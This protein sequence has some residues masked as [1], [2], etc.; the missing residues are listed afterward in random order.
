M[1]PFL[2][3][4]GDGDSL[5][6]LARLGPKLA[7]G[8]L[9][10]LRA[11]GFL[12]PIGSR[13]FEE[14]SVPDVIRTLRALWGAGSGGVRTRSTMSP[15][16]MHL[17]WLEI[18]DEPCELVLVMGDAHSLAAA[19]RRRSRALVLVPTDRAMT[20][21]LRAR[22]DSRALVRFV[23]LSE[24]LG[25]HRGRVCRVDLPVP[26]P[27]PL[28]ARA[29]ASA[30]RP[31]AAIFDGEASWEQLVLLKQD[32]RTLLARFERR[33]RRLTA[34]DLGLAGVRSRKACAPFEMLMAFCENDGCLKTRRFGNAG[35]TKATLSRL[36]AGLK[37]AFG[38]D[39]DPFHDFQRGVGWLARFGVS[40][41]EAEIERELSP[42]ARAVLERAGKVR[43]TR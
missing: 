1:R 35:A 28:P 15:A 36:R 42:G 21:E 2:Q 34:Q 5:A 7:P 3:L 18:D 8:E 24:C 20:P 9:D 19:A 33:S 13:G 11:E 23:V 31:G 16:P 27:P 43:R 26:M 37:A 38:I 6:D 25:V 32:N 12:Q 29:H 22:H 4:L 41:G 10:A 17:G 39:S 40:D 30:D 14:V